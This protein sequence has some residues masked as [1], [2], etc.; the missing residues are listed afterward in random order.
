LIKQIEATMDIANGIDALPFG[1]RPDAR[2]NFFFQAKQPFQHHGTV[3]S[4]MR[5]GWI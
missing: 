4:I 3:Y 2:R 5:D 1:R